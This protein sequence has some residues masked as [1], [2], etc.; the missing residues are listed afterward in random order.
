MKKFLKQLFCWHKWVISEKIPIYCNY[1]Y[2]KIE[3]CT[4]C[5]KMRTN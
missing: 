3:K 5:G 4:K 2:Y 1:A